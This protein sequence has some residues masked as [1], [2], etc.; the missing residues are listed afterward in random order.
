ML[1]GYLKYICNEVPSKCYIMSCVMDYV[2]D[3]IK[4]DWLEIY[5]EVC[6]IFVGG[7]LLSW[8]SKKLNVVS[9]SG[10]NIECKIKSIDILL[11]NL[12]IRISWLSLAVFIAHIR[13]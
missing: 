4:A 13:L 11:A 10:A 6:N 2:N 8:K 12:L 7:N 9:P 3:S 1:V 5:H